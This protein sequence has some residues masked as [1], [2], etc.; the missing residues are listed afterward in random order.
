MS[1]LLLDAEETEKQRKKGPKKCNTNLLG[2]LEN[3]QEVVFPSAANAGNASQLQVLATRPDRHSQILSYSTST[4][5]NP[6][7]SPAISDDVIEHQVGICKVYLTIL[8][9]D[10]P[11]IWTRSSCGLCQSRSHPNC[12]NEELHTRNVCG[13]MRGIEK[14]KIGEGVQTLACPLSAHVAAVS[15][16]SVKVA[17]KLRLPNR[18]HRFNLPDLPLRLKL[19]Q[20]HRQSA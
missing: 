5:P 20:L 9:E 6:W 16:K 14:V 7:L 8:V 17:Q 18:K 11:R 2:G 10:R 4:S 1:T 13:Y 19:L 3:G 12:S 15:S